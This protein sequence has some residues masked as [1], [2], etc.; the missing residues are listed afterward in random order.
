MPETID[1][2]S[3]LLVPQACPMTVEELLAEADG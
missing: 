1:E 3:L 2:V